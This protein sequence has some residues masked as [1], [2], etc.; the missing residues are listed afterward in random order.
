MQL[1]GCWPS[2][3]WLR[4]SLGGLRVWLIPIDLCK[5]FHGQFISVP[6]STLVFL[7]LG[8]WGAIS[9]LE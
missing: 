5:S 7:S 8:A 1:G 2:F 4:A 9:M 3:V 6:F